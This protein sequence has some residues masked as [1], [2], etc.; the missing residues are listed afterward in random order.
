MR[1]SVLIGLIAGVLIALAALSVALRTSEE[2]DPRRVSDGGPAIAPEAA[3][4]LVVEAL[5]EARALLDR[6]PA[7]TLERIGELDRTQGG[8]DPQRRAL[9]IEAHV[10]LGQIGRARSLAERFYRA[11]PQHPE[12]SRIE[13]LTGYHPRPTGPP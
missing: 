7:T 5:A 6:A 2:H 1:K 8:D 12:I 3:S 4:P 13:R 10:R 9:E 11:F